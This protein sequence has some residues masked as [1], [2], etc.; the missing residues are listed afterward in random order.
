MRGDELI[1]TPHP[2]LE[3]M[4][5]Q[6]LKSLSEAAMRTSFADGEWIFREGEAADRSY[7]IQEGNVFITFRMP[8][9]SHIV[10]QTVRTGDSLGWSYLACLEPYQW[11]FDAR[12]D[13]PTRALYF[14]ADLLG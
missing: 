2:F 14:R 1:V 4:C 13:E 5:E 7:L 11:H 8:G 3:G 6:Q 10:I 12:A 9:H